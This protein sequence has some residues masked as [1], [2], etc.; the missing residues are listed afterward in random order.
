MRPLKR[1]RTASPARDAKPPKPFMGQ[2][3]ATKPASEDVSTDRMEK[4]KLSRKASAGEEAPQPTKSRRPIS[5][6]VVQRRAV[7]VDK[8]DRKPKEELNPRQLPKSPASHQN[9]LQFLKKLHEAMSKLNQKVADDPDPSA[10]ALQLTEQQ[11]ISLALDE[12]ERQAREHPTVYANVIKMRIV[13]FM[14]MSVEVW[15]A[16]RVRD[17][18]PPSDPSS[19]VSSNP[20]AQVPAERSLDTGLSPLQERQVLDRLIAPRDGLDG[21][22]YVIA[23]PDETQIRQAEEVLRWEKNWERCERCQSRFQVFPD[24]RAEDGAVTTGGGC[25]HHHGRLQLSAKDTTGYSN[26]REKVW[27]CC[28]EPAGQHMGCTEAAS[29]VFK[30]TDVNRMA[31]I[32]QFEATPDNPSVPVDR[33]VTFDCEMGYTTKGLELL[34]LTAISWPERQTLLDILV[35]PLGIIL[36]LNTRYSGITGEQLGSAKP[37]SAET[38]AQEL[39]I[40]DSPHTARKLL[41]SLIAPSTPLIGHSIEN[42]LN[43]VRIIHPRIV[44]TVLL[45]PHPRGLPYRKSLRMLSSEC[46]GRSIQAAGAAGHDS[47][48]DCVATGDLVLVKIQREWRQMKRNGWSISEADGKLVLSKENTGRDEPVTKPPAAQ[49]A[50][51]KRRAADVVDPS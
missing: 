31:L 15:K 12:E 43:A 44:D 2:V 3:L 49:G 30:V 9:R 24:R 19:T 7:A 37:W 41:F 1:A 46:L 32:M 26:S 14:K 27:N 17:K 10:R 51:R 50:G 4:L 29:H 11:L 38:D 18:E 5:P 42:D 16:A 25:T 22:G 13:T 40:V 23:V 36:D 45:F 8:S 28:D 6:P 47:K 20:T 34:R 48:E 33:A 35:R 39:Q 21:Y